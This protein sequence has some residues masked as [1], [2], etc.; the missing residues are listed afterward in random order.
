MGSAPHRQQA[1]ETLF[2]LRPAFFHVSSVI[3]NYCNYCLTTTQLI[4][5]TRRPTSYNLTSMP[6]C[7]EHLATDKNR[8]LARS[9]DGVG[10]RLAAL[11]GPTIGNEAELPS[12]L[13]EDV[14]HLLFCMGVRIVEER[15][16]ELFTR[17]RFVRWPQPLEKR[18]EGGVFDLTIVSNASQFVYKY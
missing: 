13:R 15:A 18:L 16:G 4:D 11:I 3:S 12:A 10:D 17:R 9:Y 5:Y 14:I 7:A 6:L 1:G 2:Q 8:V